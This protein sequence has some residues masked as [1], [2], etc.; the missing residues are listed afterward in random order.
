MT[1]AMTT[2][3]PTHVQESVERLVAFL[4]T[5]ATDDLFAPGVF[6]DLTLPGRPASI[7]RPGGRGSRR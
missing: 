3:L 2:E 7:R 4:E 6:A 1:T 5:G